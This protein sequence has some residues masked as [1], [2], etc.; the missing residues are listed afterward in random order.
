MAD[1]LTLRYTLLTAF[2]S[3]A[4]VA[5]ENVAAVLLESFDFV[6][7][8]VAGT[9]IITVGFFIALA[10]YRDNVH[11]MVDD[12]LALLRPT[13]IPSTPS[14]TGMPDTVQYESV[15]DNKFHN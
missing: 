5:F 15:E 1:R 8:M 2:C 11:A 12:A 4:Y 13:A 7:T 9:A 3:F 10:M 14:G 6:E